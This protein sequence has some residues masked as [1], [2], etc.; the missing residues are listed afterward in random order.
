MSTDRGYDPGGI[1]QIVFVPT[2]GGVEISHYTMNAARCG[3]LVRVLGL[4]GVAYAHPDM[5][6]RANLHYSVHAVDGERYAALV[7]RESVVAGT[8]KSTRAHVLLGPARLLGPDVAVRLLAA[9]PWSP[10][11][12]PLTGQLARITSADLATPTDV[13]PP[14]GADRAALS[15][16]AIELI[17]R[18]NEDLIVKLAPEHRAPML[19]D[20]HRLIGPDALAGGFSLHEMAVDDAQALPRLVFVTGWPRSDIETSRRRIDLDGVANDPQ[21][22][23]TLEYLLQGLL[24]AR[25]NGTPAEFLDRLVPGD[26]HG[27]TNRRLLEGFGFSPLMPA[28]VG[29]LPAAPQ[30]LPKT[31]PPVEL[32]PEGTP[33]PEGAPPP[34]IGADVEDPGS[35]V[36]TDGSTAPE[37]APEPALE[38][39]PEPL[40][41]PARDPEEDA[42]RDPEWK[43]ERKTPLPELPPWVSAQRRYQPQQPPYQPPSVENDDDEQGDLLGA[44][45]IVALVAAALILIALVFNTGLHR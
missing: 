34:A 2:R 18:P 19:G 26:P 1:E 25:A 41:N 40:R 32:E 33:E 39:A 44:F 29:P 23:G 43:P 14:Q 31:K 12:D 35:A 17:T 16:L 36:P 3:Q 30:P 37:P 9:W 5:A 24:A 7:N 21:A 10:E 6:G 11:P 20:L 22:Q 15:R 27:R 8:R 28:V 45:A 38:P 13:L 4:S 42:E